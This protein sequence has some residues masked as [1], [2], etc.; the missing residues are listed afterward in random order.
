MNE[1][2]ERK[3][4]QYKKI[5][6]NQDCITPKNNIESILLYG[7][8]KEQDKI[9]L[10]YVIPTFN[11]PDFLKSA[12]K[13]ILDQNSPFTFEIIIVDNS[14]NMGKDN[15]NLLIAEAYDD[16]HI[17]F[18][19]NEKNLGA[20]GNWNRGISLARGEYVALLHDDDLLANNY[21]EVI[22]QA[23]KTAV[24]RKKK[25]G[26]IVP[27]RID[28]K[29]EKEITS[30]NEKYMGI[31]QCQ[32]VNSLVVDLIGPTCCPT[33]GMLFSKEAVLH[34]GGFNDVYEPACDYVLGYQMLN[35]GYAVYR[36]LNTVGY[37]R[38]AGN[39]SSNKDIYIQFCKADFCFREYMYSENFM[40][41][42]FGHVFRTIEYS[43]SLNGLYE[44]ANRFDI[45]ISKKEL[46]FLG[47]KKNN[48]ILFLMF[49][50]IR[51][52]V[53]IITSRVYY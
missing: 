8:R 17:F 35:S 9:F 20:P 51:K 28:F 13:S 6:E 41:R 47:E 24:K 52:F 16:E 2:L 21:A 23:I 11:R 48:K 39:A 44:N 53:S 10:S 33:C 3:I 26:A 49:R 18:Y 45:N 14:E 1:I 38:T 5:S 42:I 22:Y 40:S 37:Y 34:V 50:I 29:D 31:K 32:K 27:N 7:K 15:P 43:I 30:I 25:I 19:V 4:S 46:D 12:I 36:A